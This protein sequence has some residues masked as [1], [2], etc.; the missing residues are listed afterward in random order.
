MGRCKPRYCSLDIAERE[1]D[2]AERE[3]KTGRRL[4][5]RLAREEMLD[6]LFRFLSEDEKWRAEGLD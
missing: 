4:L 6:D 1:F 2:H 3:G 5:W